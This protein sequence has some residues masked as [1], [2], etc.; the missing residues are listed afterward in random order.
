MLAEN[1]GSG[2]AAATAS[3]VCRWSPFKLETNSTESLWLMVSL[4][5]IAKDE[6]RWAFLAPEGLEL[7]GDRGGHVDEGAEDEIV[8]AVAVQV[9]GFKG[10]PPAGHTW[11]Q[12]PGFEIPFPA[13]G[14]A[15]VLEIGP[16]ATSW[17]GGM[18][19]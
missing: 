13:A 4:R 17:I 16:A 6:Y 10:D 11:A 14:G 5:L 1:V 12:G 2:P 9:A 7:V 8:V 19:L 3:V 15:G 18:P